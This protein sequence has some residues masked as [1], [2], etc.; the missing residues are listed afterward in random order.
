MKG[1]TPGLG[2]RQHE[3]ELTACVNSAPAGN[4]FT[5]TMSALKHYPSW[6]TTYGY[7]TQTGVDKALAAV[8]TGYT[9]FV[10]SVKAW[11]PVEPQVTAMSNGGVA[12]SL[13]YHVV[14][15]AREV[16]KDFKNET[17]QTLL[18]GH[19]IKVMVDPK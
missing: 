14:A 15:G 4:Y 2:V 18:T 7:I 1:Y 12:D 5:D 17:L 10:P 3:T 11:K 9:L 19:S 8:T 13:R 6:I 16:P